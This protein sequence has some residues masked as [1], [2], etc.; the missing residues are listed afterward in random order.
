MAAKNQ[1]AVKQQVPG[2]GAME[3][4]KLFWAGR[5]RQQRVYLGVGLA[6]TL[7]VAAFF[8][9]VLSTPDYKLLMS[10]LEAS[11]AQAISAELTGKKI[12]FRVSPDGA[13]IMVPADQLDAARLEVASH[14]ATQSG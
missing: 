5:S 4:V 3:R 10:G 14:D 2:V 6:V 11:D 12:P 13:S 9:K 7:G 8:T 1:V